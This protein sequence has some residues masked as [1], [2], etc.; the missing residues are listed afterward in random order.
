[1]ALPP[2]A[3]VIGAGT[4]G[5]AIAHA[6]ALGG[7]AV[8]LHD[9]DTGMLERALAR[10]EQD[11]AAA[12]ERRR[13]D[14]RQATAARANLEPS[15][16]L[17]DLAGAQLVIEAVPE[18]LELKRAVFAE[19]AN[20]C[21]EECLLATNTSS[22]LVSAIAAAVPHPERVVGMHF[23]NPATRMRLVEVVPGVQT[24]SD[25]VARA[26][27]FVESIGKQAITAR[28]GI[29]FIVNRGAR[30]FY[31]EALR[32]VTE[33]VASVGQ[34]DRICRV[35]GGFR[36]GPFELIDLIGVDVNFEI[37]TSFFEQSFG[38]PRWRPSPLQARLVA[39]GQLG[40]KSGRGFYDY[41]DGAY[42]EDDRSPPEPRGGAGRSVVID[43]HTSVSLA[44]R[45]AASAAGFVLDTSANRSPWLRVDCRLEQHEPIAASSSVRLCA[46]HS[47]SAHPQGG[48]AG[49]HV[50]PSVDRISL[51]ELCADERTDP[52]ALGRARE[53]FAALGAVVEQV[54]DA[55]GLVLGRIVCQLINEAAFALAEGVGSAEDIDLGMTLG[56]NH[57]RGPFAWRELIG[58]E[59]V[60]AVLTGLSEERGPER[61]QPAPSL[62]FG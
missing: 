56:L 21:S 16:R 5:A 25:T 9:V 22:L 59:H 40:R 29:G 43:G 45:D 6:L 61:Y 23:F 53:F 47:L 14:E 4:M 55:P 58:T 11:I 8:Q 46:R 35:G 36:M 54:G 20:V 48:A 1:M 57:P 44:I 37:S 19:L 39:A 42:R 27:A 41:R 51:V 2:Q 7:I 10:I 15:S 12:V 17:A 24:S 34:I 13:L 52:V 49:F 33:G 62:M 3:G 60:R 38:E 28:D 32:L 31:G 26:R 18:R 50:L 30:P